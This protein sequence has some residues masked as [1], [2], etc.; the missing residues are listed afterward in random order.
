[1]YTRKRCETGDARVRD[2]DVYIL[3]FFLGHPDV[4]VHVATKN[5][6]GFMAQHYQGSVSMSEIHVATK[7]HS[8]ASGMVC[9][10]CP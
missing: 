5:M 9:S 4:L 7:D 2:L 8:I 10:L 6:S 1:M 3:S